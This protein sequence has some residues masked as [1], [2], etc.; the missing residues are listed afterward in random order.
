MWVP[1]GNIVSGVFT[2]VIAKHSKHLN[3]VDMCFDRSENSSE[4]F[5]SMS[6]QIREERRA[7]YGI[8]KEST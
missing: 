1:L 2:T 7:Y 6:A 5:Y 4:R 8:L 3:L